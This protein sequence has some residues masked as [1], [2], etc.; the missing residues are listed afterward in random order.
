MTATAMLVIN[1]CVGI[2]TLLLGIVVS[3]LRD[4]IK[5][6]KT[7]IKSLM[8]EK[9]CNMHHEGHKKEHSR[10]E[11]DINGLGSK[12]ANMSDHLTEFTKEI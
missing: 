7:E 12:V 5:D 10:I 11:R 6:L 1:I 8:T 9:V 2:I 4:E 3:Q